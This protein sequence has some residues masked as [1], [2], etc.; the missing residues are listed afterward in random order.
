[1]Q[2]AIRQPDVESFHPACTFK[3][4]LASPCT[5]PLFPH[6]QLLSRELN[7][8]GFPLWRKESGDVAF[9]LRCF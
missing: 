6:G 5:T 7:D 8:P 1:M 3:S 2:P 4:R 9:S